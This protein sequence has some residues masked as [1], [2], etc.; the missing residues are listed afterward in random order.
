MSRTWKE[1][2][3]EIADLERKDIY[4]VVAEKGASNGGGV[5]FEQELHNADYEGIKKRI[6]Q[7]RNY[8]PKY[9]YGKCRIAKLV[10]IDQKTNHC[11]HKHITERQPGEGSICLDCG[12]R[13]TKEY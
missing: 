12:K 13:Y 4:V 11:Q 5:V 6:V 3:E 8:Y 2:T 9:D 10:F 7:I 1:V